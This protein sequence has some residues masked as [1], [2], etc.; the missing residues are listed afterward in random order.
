MK[1]KTVRF[2]AIDGGQFDSVSPESIPK[3]GSAR[4]INFLPYHKRLNVRAGSSLWAILPQEYDFSIPP[5]GPTPEAWII[6][7]MSEGSVYVPG[8][9]VQVDGLFWY[10]AA[11]T[12][13]GGVAHSGYHYADPVPPGAPGDPT[14]GA[15]GWIY[16]PNGSIA[17]PSAPAWAYAPPEAPVVFV[18]NGTFYSF[19][20][21][22]YESIGGIA[23]LEPLGLG[24]YASPG[25]SPIT[26]P[27]SFRR[28]GVPI[29]QVDPSAC[30]PVTKLRGATG[31]YENYALVVMDKTGGVRLVNKEGGTF[32][33]KLTDLAEPSIKS[34]DMPWTMRQY[35]GIVYAVRRESTR[36][37]RIEGSRMLD[38][39]RPAGEAMI[40]NGGAITA[41]G[42]GGSL[43]GGTYMLSYGLYDSVSGYPGNEGPATAVVVPA[44]TTGSI[45]LT[46]AALGLVPSDDSA[47]THY[48]VY[49]SRVGGQTRY[50]VSTQPLGFVNNIII[51]AEPTSSEIAPT[52][53]AQP[54]ADATCFEVWGER[55]WIS[56]GTYLK[57]SDFRKL[58]GYSNLQNLDFN[59]NDNDDITT[60]KAWG[61]YLVIAKR[62][63][64]VLL[65][66]LDR[67]SFDQKL[68]TD[69]VGCVA[70]HTMQD[71]EGLLVWL[72]ENGF[73][74]ARAGETPKNI[75]DAKVRRALAY[76]SP[77]ARET[78]VACVLPGINLYVVTFR[79][80]VGGVNRTWMLVYNWE[81]NAWG[82]V[83]WPF[84]P[85]YLLTGF[86]ADY[87]TVI[88]GLDESLY[89]VWRMFDGSTDSGEEIEAEWLTR[90]PDVTDSPSQLAGFSRV[91]LLTSATRWPI[92]LRGYEA[93]R[94]ENMPVPSSS[95]LTGN[96]PTVW[97]PA[98]GLFLEDDEES[99]AGPLLRKRE[100]QLRGDV[101]WKDIAFNTTHK[102]RSQLQLRVTYKG[103][104]P[105]WISDM[106]WELVLK[107][108]TRRY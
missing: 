106:A 55:G 2:Q 87:R 57:Y 1:R 42:T 5:P 99:N 39:G 71:C 100:V 97:L 47:N 90:S 91:H 31:L 64:A 65:T 102:M 37:R 17:F 81:E 49:M 60:L 78:A 89:K 48:R 77:E 83:S 58:E 8:D 66:G 29:D 41:S 104:D 36:M 19:E 59:P 101:G 23:E 18:P 21:K 54:D 84:S 69:R 16:D 40:T 63:A 38:A 82:E 61:D 12:N 95:N 76:M 50:L 25:D 67:Q 79:A 43:V 20:G 11:P 10:F 34:D 107:G 9:Y 45:T 27:Q 93:S 92:T 14:Q 28:Y 52:R 4:L 85:T 86:G 6:P 3:N 75:S 62:R 51:G 105:F 88:F 94:M 7:E 70:P 96:N 68:W 53:Q 32:T 80:V 13:Y 46:P 33:A 56:N 108:A 30:L 98:S 103:K 74:S 73:V 35:N 44:G 26:R 72:S 22:I 15:P 24:W